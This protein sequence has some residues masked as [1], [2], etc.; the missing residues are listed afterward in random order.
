M[1]LGVRQGGSYSDV[2]EREK[3]GAKGAWRKQGYS[4]VLSSWIGAEGVIEMFKMFS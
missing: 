1:P 2:P 4:S 3:L